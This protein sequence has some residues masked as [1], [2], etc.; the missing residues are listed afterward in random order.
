MNYWV[1]K[2]EPE[3]YSWD[4]FVA[5]KEDVWDGVRNYQARNFLREMQMGD[6]VFFYHSG[7]EKAIVGIA[8]VSQEKFPDPTDEKWTAVKLRVNRP[9]KN[10]VSLAAMK[11]E[12]RLTGLP[13]LKQSRLSVSNVGKEEFDLL[14]K[15]GS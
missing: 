11:A 2:S 9:L 13:M 4:D 14:L 7:K 5:I 1:V 10:P 6:L 15:M 12:D 3:S 8:E